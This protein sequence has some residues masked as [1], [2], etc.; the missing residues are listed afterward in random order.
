M[1]APQLNK[2]AK[3]RELLRKKF[4]EKELEQIRFSFD[5]LGD[6]ATINPMPKGLAKKEKIFA[7]AIM[8]EH[9]N[10]KVVAKKT[11]ATSGVERIRKVKVVLGEKRTD[12]VYI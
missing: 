2:M 3:L 11:N 8:D 6:I 5:V 10:I 9:R 12:T 7:K 4:S 1:A